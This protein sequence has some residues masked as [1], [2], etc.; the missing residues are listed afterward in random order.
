MHKILDEHPHVAMARGK[1]I[2][3][4][5]ESENDAINYETYLTNFDISSDTKLIGEASP[6]YANELTPDSCY[7]RILETLSDEVFLVY[8]VRDPLERIT[9]HFFH[10]LRMGTE[11]NKFASAVK[12]SD[13]YFGASNYPKQIELV[14]Q[15]FNRVPHLI[16]FS[17]FVSN[18][19]NSAK[20]LIEL[21]G[22]DPSL[23]PEEGVDHFNIGD[24]VGVNANRNPFRFKLLM[25]SKLFVKSFKKFLPGKLKSKVK[26]VILGDGAHNRD[27]LEISTEKIKIYEE[28]KEF[29]STTAEVMSETYAVNTDKWFK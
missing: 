17:E 8:M 9:S 2:N 28:N 23:L 5:I 25:F 10:R 11:K 20:D 19:R 18:P 15:R 4:F 12:S 27:S 22:L 21:M 1:E 24:K 7:D 14:K 29:F 3:F 16:E 26:K 6:R 13:V